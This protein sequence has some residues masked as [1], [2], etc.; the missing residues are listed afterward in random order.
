MYE[1]IKYSFDA[2][3]VFLFGIRSLCH[4]LLCIRKTISITY[5]SLY[6][7]P[8]LHPVVNTTLKR[9]TEMSAAKLSQSQV[10]IKEI[11]R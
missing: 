2:T 4:M 10:I 7:Y 11:D 5:Y 6:P 3:T 1:E 9:R 8:L